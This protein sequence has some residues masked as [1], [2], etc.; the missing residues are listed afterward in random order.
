[1][2]TML[3]RSDFVPPPALREEMN[4]PSSREADAAARREPVDEA[5]HDIAGVELAAGCDQ[6]LADHHSELRVV[7]PVRA[8]CRQ[9]GDP[10]GPVPGEDSLPGPGL[11]HGEQHTAESPAEALLDPLLALGRASVMLPLGRAAGGAGV[12]G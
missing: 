7:G 5:A 10:G 3:L 8:F 12:E 9:I 2:T 11:D 1:M 6:A 4:R